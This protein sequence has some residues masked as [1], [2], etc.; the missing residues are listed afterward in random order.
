MKVFFLAFEGESYLIGQ[1]A[2]RLKSKGNQVFIFNC[3]HYTVT[4]QNGQVG[5]YYT[6]ECGLSTDEFTN[7]E[8]I[9]VDLSQ[10]NENLP[11]KEVDIEYV[12]NFESKYC[13]NSKINDLISKDTLMSSI[14]HHRDIYYHPNNKAIHYKHLELVLKKVEK[15]FIKEEFDC[16]FT[17]SF[18][19]FYKAL[20]FEI[21]SHLDRPYFCLTGVR[22][23][24]IH[25][26]IN[27]FCLGTPDE[28]SKEM[29]RLE[30]LN[31]C[32]NEAT[33]YM[34]EIINKN[35]HPYTSFNETMKNIRN[36]LNLSRR[37][38]NDLKG[39]RSQLKTRILKWK[40]YRK[41]PAKDYFLP[42][43]R[44]ILI[45]SL[46]GILRSQF[47]QRDSRLNHQELPSENFVYFAMHLIPESSTLTLS[48]TLDEMEC[49]YQLSK[50]LP[51]DWKLVVK[52]NPN[53]LAGFDTH[54]NEYYQRI[55]KLPNVIFINPLYQSSAIVKQ[56]KAVASLTGTVLLES[57]IIGKPA[58]RW[59]MT[60]FADV[61][62]I[63]E[64][65]RSLFELDLSRSVNSNVK[66]YIQAC[67]N[68]G[69]HLDYNYLVNTQD[70]KSSIYEKQV[71]LIENKLH[72]LL[73]FAK[74]VKADSKSTEY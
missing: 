18:Q 56:A 31:D 36:N 55:N 25:C 13:K 15:I 61:N 68:V 65:N 19:Y 37:L 39:L 16:V 58:F 53:M 44:G 49:I 11:M 62:G 26:I 33:E 29:K 35:N 27:N 63:Y 41:F 46:T 22:I 14:Y 1:L 57:A 10:F 6:T 5:N 59:G 45:A 34:N 40:R 72:Q 23:K 32:C 73:S 20:I 21:S 43:Y 52:M 74:P 60:E 51:V 64:F 24:D 66:Y 38:T 3:D 67:F 48:P 54:P 42:S 4:H 71:E 69:L 17:N 28:I 30:D 2:K 12:A 50:L 47:Y 8:D 70:I 9:F 7:L